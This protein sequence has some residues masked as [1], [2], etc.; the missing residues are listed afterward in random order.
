MAQGSPVDT[1]GRNYTGAPT[2][3]PYCSSR[4][5]RAE[6]DEGTVAEWNPR[7]ALLQFMLA[8]AALAS[9]VLARWRALR[10]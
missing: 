2:T 7:G 6:R 3:L 5:R 4:S 8:L 1:R 9:V 10:A